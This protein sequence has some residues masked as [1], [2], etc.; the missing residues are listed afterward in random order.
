MGKESD[1]RLLALDYLHEHQVMTL[2]TNGDKG[3]WA[4]AVFYVNENFTLY[5]LSAGH[6]R[7][8][9]NISASNRAAA[10][11]HE[12]YEDWPAIKGIQLEGDV[13]QLRGSKRQH[14]LT[15]YQNKYPFIK[16]AVPQLRMSL[17]KVNWYC[18]VPDRL[19]FI[20]NS[21]GLGHRDLV[22]LR[23]PFESIDKNMRQ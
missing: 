23:P 15:L 13:R 12:D 19:Y 11:I 21:K 1:V 20:D 7:H 6:T 14:A 8:A 16:G 5:F 10:A 18:L 4:A 17:A 9:Q 22:D 2:A 3:P